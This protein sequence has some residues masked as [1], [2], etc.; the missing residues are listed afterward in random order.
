MAVIHWKI[1]LVSHLFRVGQL[2]LIHTHEKNKMTIRN[3]QIKLANFSSSGISFNWMKRPA[4]IEQLKSSLHLNSNRNKKF[5]FSHDVFILPL[6]LYIILR[7]RYIKKKIKCKI[8]NH[9]IL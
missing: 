9:L 2:E 7:I 4:I 1:N 8:M 5:S 3:S 6:I